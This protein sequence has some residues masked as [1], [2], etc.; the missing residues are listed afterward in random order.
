MTRRR[1][2]RIRKVCYRF[3]RRVEDRPADGLVAGSV[4]LYA[5]VNALEQWSM[6]RASRCG[7]ITGAVD[8][9]PYMPPWLHAVEQFAAT[10][11]AVMY[12]R[13]EAAAGR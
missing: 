6:I 11:R 1:Y 10:A 3:Y 8:R 4:A 5:A 12:D 2:E 9:R 7:A 13:A